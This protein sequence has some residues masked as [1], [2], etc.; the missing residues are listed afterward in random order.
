VS[1]LL[2]AALMTAGHDEIRGKGPDQVAAL[3]AHD[4]TW[5]FPIPGSNRIAITSLSTLTRRGR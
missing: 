3:E 5:V 2:E 4:S 1:G